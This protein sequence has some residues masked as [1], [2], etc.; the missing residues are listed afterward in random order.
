MQGQE[1]KQYDL[2]KLSDINLAR[3]YGRR[4]LSPLYAKS[5]NLEHGFTRI[6]AGRRYFEAVITAR[7]CKTRIMRP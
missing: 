4:E 2:Y 5:I 6:K 3:V 7:E 1:I